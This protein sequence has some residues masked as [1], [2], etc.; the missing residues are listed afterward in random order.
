[1]DRQTVVVD[2]L[3]MSEVHGE[4]LAT[5]RFTEPAQPA[6]GVRTTEQVIVGYEPIY[7]RLTTQTL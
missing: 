6:N 3:Q 4:L 7:G 1:V 5:G 2:L